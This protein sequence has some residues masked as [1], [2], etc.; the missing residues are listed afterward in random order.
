MSRK[1]KGIALTTAALGLVVLVA[2]GFASKNFF[3]EEWEILQL[4]WRDAEAKRTAIDWLGSKQSERAILKVIFTLRRNE[5]YL[6]Q[7]LE[8]ITGANTAK[9]LNLST[10]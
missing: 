6:A 3:L 1:G 4:S 9:P 10:E 8:Q 7:A 2:V 5:V